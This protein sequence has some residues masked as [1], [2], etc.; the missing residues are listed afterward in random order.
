[1]NEAASIQT[2]LSVRR[3]LHSFLLVFSIHIAALLHCST[4]LAGEG[5]T[6]WIPEWE[7][8]LQAARREGQVNVYATNLE[9]VLDSR[10][11]EKSYPGI[12]VSGV[13]LGRSPDLYKRISAERRAEKY[14]A[15]V[16]INGAVELLDFHKARILDPIKPLL[17]LPEVRDE[18]KWWKGQ[19][20]YLDAE[21]QYVFRYVSS[22]SPGH[23]FYNT[24]MV[25]PSEFKSLWDFVDPKWKGKISAYDPEAGGPAGSGMRFFYHNAELGPKF[26]RRLFSEMGITFFRDIRQGMDWLAVGKFPICFFCSSPDIR[27][28]QK[29]GL[30]VAGFGPLKEGTALTSRHGVIAIQNKAPHP[31]SARVFIN[32]YLSREGQSTFQR[33]LAK[34][35]ESPPES[36]RIDIP[37]DDIPQDERR[38]E[39]VSYIELDRLGTDMRSILDIY[40]EALADTKKK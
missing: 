37:K 18:S 19:H 32:W 20:R 1:M 13:V 29:Q 16:I 17:I 35:G 7:R 28:A 30:P 2:T 4:A 25:N 22:P 40:R 9:E 38:V 33:G 39:G 10:V 14:L 8:T 3:L 27:R 15:D 11:F 5:K 36:L 23:V 6:D 26:I 31:H 24:K 21:G 34:S 12:K